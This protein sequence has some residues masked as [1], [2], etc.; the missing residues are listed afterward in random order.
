MTGFNA[1]KLTV[2]CGAIFTVWRSQLK[3]V[4]VL[5]AAS[6]DLASF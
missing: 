4:F 1:V 5:F 3:A 2:E 6:I